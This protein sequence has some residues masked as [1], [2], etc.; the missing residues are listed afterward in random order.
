MEM[1]IQNIINLYTNT[2]NSIKDLVVF[3]NKSEETIRRFMIKNNIK[4]KDK[5]LKIKQYNK[6]KFIGKFQRKDGY[7]LILVNNKYVLEHRF[8][9]E[10]NIGRKLEKYE[11][12]H[13]KNEIK[14]D[15]R[16]ENLEILTI[17]EHSK[18]HKKEKDL[19]KYTN[20]LCLYCGKQFNRLTAE[21]KNHPK[22]YCNREH[23][24]KG[25]KNETI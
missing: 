15:N 22:T 7:I 21:V 10:N 19:T 23:Y 18:Y 20:C 4:R 9:V 11:H 17:S 14:N 13:H 24:L 6:D 16:I 3:F 25:V 2:N 1:N 8:I 5:T 12:V